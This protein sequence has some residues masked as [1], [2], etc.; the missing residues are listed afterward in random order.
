MLKY[1][2]TGVV[3]SKTAI[4]LIGLAVAGFAWITAK[5]VKKPPKQEDE[6]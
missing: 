1:F 4:V 3:L 6:R 2:I 5:E